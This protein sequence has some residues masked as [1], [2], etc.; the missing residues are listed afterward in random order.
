MHPSGL[1]CFKAGVKHHPI[2]VRLI[3]KSY[4]HWMVAEGAGVRFVVG[5]V[6]VRV[7]VA[8]FADTLTYMEPEANA[9]VRITD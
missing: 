4:L 8:E 6:D 5:S 1:P 3:T 7:A 2:S 9:N